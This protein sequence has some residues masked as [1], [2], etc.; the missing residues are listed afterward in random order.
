MI[1]IRVHG[2]PAGQGSKS[3]KGRWGGR[4]VLADSNEKALIPWRD[5]VRA[6][7]QRVIEA[8][9]EPIPSGPVQ[10]RALVI[11][12]RPKSHY[13]T[14]RSAHRLRE[15]APMWCA[16][17]PDLDKVARSICD[18]LTDAGA[19][20]DDKQVAHLDMRQIYATADSPGALIT[21]T[22]L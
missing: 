16:K 9:A 21:I 18:A 8:G 15:D 6:E 13:R 1:T 5:A 22:A 3:Y 19:W 2:T 4:P 12:A 11:V 10:M 14:G 17:S 20:G 7:A